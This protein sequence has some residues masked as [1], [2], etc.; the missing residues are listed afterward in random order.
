MQQLSF[1]EFVRRALDLLAQELPWAYSA[2][3]ES[4]G[5]RVLGV[6]VDGSAF[7]IRRAGAELVVDGAPLPL[8]VEC[9]ASRAT[10]LE[11]IDARVTLLDSVLDRRLSLRGSLHDLVAFHEALT[12]FVGGAVRCPSF[13]SLLASYRG[14]S[15]QSGAISGFCASGAVRSA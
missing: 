1:A 14:Q 3:G 2:L 12:R 9:I 5:E 4:V 11:L 10:I 7:A 6:E 8:S 15:A 13:P